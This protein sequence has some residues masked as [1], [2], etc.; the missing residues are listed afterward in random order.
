VIRTTTWF[1]VALGLV[2]AL[3]TAVGVY[4]ARLDERRVIE[5]DGEWRL[6]HR[7]LQGPFKSWVY[8]YRLRLSFDGKRLVGEGE[9]LSVNGHAPGS[10]ERTT[11]QVVNGMIRRGDV[12]AWVF[13]RNGERAG[14]GAI[15]WHIDGP[16]LLIG[17][18]ATT[19]HRGASV[20][21]RV[22]PELADAPAG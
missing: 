11:L 18:F 7:V 21:R 8:E 2:V 22:D 19:F 10:G 4:Q 15:R 3:V 12:I 16:D 17:S 9:T 5:L 6:Q 20:A 13:E 14:R 1:L